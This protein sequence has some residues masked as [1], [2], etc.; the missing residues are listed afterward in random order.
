MIEKWID[1]VQRIRK[2]YSQ[3]QV[4]RDRKMTF[5]FWTSSDFEPKALECLLYHK[6]RNTKITLD[7]KTEGTSWPLLRK[8]N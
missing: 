3:I 8:I 1:R 7:W 5:S 6:K 4:Y 2:Y